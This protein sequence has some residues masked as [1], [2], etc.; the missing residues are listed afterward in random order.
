MPALFYNNISF[1]KK[2]KSVAFLA[3][4][5]TLSGCVGSA[6]SSTDSQIGSSDWDSLTWDKNDWG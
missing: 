2:L 5:M 6:E 3:L 4:L 1:S